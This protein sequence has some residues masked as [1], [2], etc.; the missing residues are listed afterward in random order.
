MDDIRDN[1]IESELHSHE[2]IYNV[3]IA[4][5][6]LYS[7]I[8]GIDVFASTIG[9]CIILGGEVDTKRNRIVLPK[10]EVNFVYVVTHEAVHC[11]QH[12][13]YAFFMNTPLNFGRY[14]SWK[15]EGYAE[16]ISQK[17]R[18]ALDPTSI[19]NV[20]K[21][22]E[23]NKGEGESKWIELGKSYTMP[24][25]YLKDRVLVEYLIQ[26]KDMSYTDIIKGKFEVDE[27]FEEIKTWSNRSAEQ[28]TARNG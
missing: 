24:L 1:L 27:L 15:I 18:I 17:K 19:S 25:A 26:I 3:V 4:G 22:I 14:P 2:L 6:G 13:E 9:N 10:L 23:E 16:W 8:D 7:K 11:E 12:K 20:I 21:K 5:D 28:G